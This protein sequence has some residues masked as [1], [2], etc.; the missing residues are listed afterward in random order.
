MLSSLEL[1][2]GVGWEL[3]GICLYTNNTSR[4]EWGHLERE[5]LRTFCEQLDL[6]EPKLTA[7]VLY[8]QV[9]F[10]FTK[11]FFPLSN[12]EVLII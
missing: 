5:I 11:P 3:G 7:A 4:S 12:P 10:L 8:K 6:A 9:E 2:W 1:S